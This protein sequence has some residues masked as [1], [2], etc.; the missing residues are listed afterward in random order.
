MKTLKRYYIVVFLSFIG[1]ANVN[2]GT[3]ELPNSVIEAVAAFEAARRHPILAS[4]LGLLSIFG[5]YSAIKNIIGMGMGWGKLTT[6]KNLDKS[7]IK[8]EVAN[9]ETQKKIQKELA[10]ALGGEY[11]EYK[12]ITIKKD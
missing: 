7:L 2:G 3:L 10:S 4:S 8:I 11:T 6:L 9:D 12:G 5:G 1:T